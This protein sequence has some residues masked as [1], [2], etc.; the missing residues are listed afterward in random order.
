MSDL[1]EKKLNLNN[2]KMN[3]FIKKGA[4]IQRYLG[5]NNEG[6]SLIFANLN[7]CHCFGNVENNWELWTNDKIN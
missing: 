4:L 1:F 5:F 6:N 3:L 7:L 2:L